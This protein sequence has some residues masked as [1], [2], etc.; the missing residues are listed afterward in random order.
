MPSFN[1]PRS[2]AGGGASGCWSDG[3]IGS[4]A[5]LER[6]VRRF[7]RES[8]SQHGRGRIEERQN[9]GPAV[10][11]ERRERWAVGVWKRVWYAPKRFRLSRRIGQWHTAASGGVL[12]RTTWD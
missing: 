8:L 10:R 12:R 6:K 7:M 9:A 2:G 11:P 5:M 1:P 4:A 3:S